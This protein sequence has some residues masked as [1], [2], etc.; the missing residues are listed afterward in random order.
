MTDKLKLARDGDVALVTLDDPASLNALGP[1]LCVGLVETFGELAADG[2]TR[3]AVLTGEG[4]AFSSGAN[5]AEAASLLAGG[6]EPDL[7]AL[8]ERFYNPVAE[9]LRDLPFPL[10][11]A[12]N[13]VAAG[14]GCAFALAG[15]LIVAADGA[16]FSVAFRRVGLV[17]DGGTTWLLPRRVG[18]ARAMEMVLLGESVDA[19]QALDWGLINRCVPA[20]ALMP[21]AL[22]IARRLA[23]GPAALAAARRLL[24]EGLDRPWGDQ[25][26]AEAAAQ[27]AAGRTADFREGVTA[28]LQKREPRFRGE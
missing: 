10:V 23:E 25:L 3:A 27:G 21:E 14:I 1:D 26:A 28:F 16:S 11:T 5:L 17:P 19:A 20:E 4:R 13:G 9:R 12:V 7:Q 15:D 18:L 24:R 6:G 22:A 2:R 8:V